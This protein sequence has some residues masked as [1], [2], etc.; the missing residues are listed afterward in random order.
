MQRSTPTRV[1]WAVN[2]P[3]VGG[4]VPCPVTVGLGRLVCSPRWSDQNVW[5]EAGRKALA[6]G[7][8]T[9]K[10]SAGQVSS[11]VCTT[12]WALGYAGHL[13]S[14]EPSRLSNER[15]GQV[16]P[17][18]SCAECMP[19]V[20]GNVLVLC[21]GPGMQGGPGRSGGATVGQR[22]GDWKGRR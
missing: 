21:A 20:A 16:E 11:Q 12:P 3:S 19:D 15:P 17:G 8:S 13:P 2:A 9:G 14:P 22:E 1:L 18:V 4:Q 6:G 7:A 10:E 5:C